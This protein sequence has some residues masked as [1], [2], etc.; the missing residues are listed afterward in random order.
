MST[1]TIPTSCGLP[2]C[3]D[4][5]TERPLL[6]GETISVFER[7][8]LKS[9]QYHTHFLG[10]VFNRVFRFVPGIRA[11]TR[12]AAR[13][14]EAVLALPGFSRAG[15]QVIGIAQKLGGPSSFQKAAPH[16]SQPGLPGRRSRC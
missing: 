10:L 2:A 14:D 13:L 15:L 6:Y 16:M 11:V 5:A 12:Y 3:I 7:V 1:R 4:H 9:L 8:G